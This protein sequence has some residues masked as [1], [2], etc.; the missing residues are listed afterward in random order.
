MSRAPLAQQ[1]V[2]LGEVDAR[3]AD[4]PPRNGGFLD[5]DALAVRDRVLLDHD[6]ISAIGNDAAGEDPHGLAGA[7]RS[8]KRP[9]RRDL[10]DQGE[11]GID[12]RRIDRA[13]RIAVHCR[14]R[15]RRLRAP[16]RDIAREHAVEG[17]VER[18]HLFR[19]RLCARQH[20]SERV[21]NRHQGHG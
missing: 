13:H 18:D 11:R 19:Q 14:H 1:H 20:R 3:G 16:R 5:R 7:D 9:A 17:C 2:A 6:R 21:G 8:C 12:L 4:V 15:L 10:A